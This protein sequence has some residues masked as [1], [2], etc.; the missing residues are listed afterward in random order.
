MQLIKKFNNSKSKNSIFKYFKNN[1]HLLIIIINFK[2][3]EYVL[4]RVYNI[5]LMD[6]QRDIKK[7]CI[8][9]H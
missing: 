6:F 3:I 1:I 5:V 9:F 7:R 2:E 8:M 4:K